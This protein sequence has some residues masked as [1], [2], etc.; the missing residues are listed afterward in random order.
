[1]LTALSISFT[2]SGVE[3]EREPLS[4]LLGVFAEYPPCHVPDTLFDVGWFLL[5]ISL[6]AFFETVRDYFSHALVLTQVLGEFIY[7]YLDQSL[8]LGLI[9]HHVCV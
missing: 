5:P 7:S 1:M 4:C 2:Y 6:L 9:S 3:V 8:V